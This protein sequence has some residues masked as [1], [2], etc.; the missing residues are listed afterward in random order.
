MVDEMSFV[1]AHSH[2]AHFALFKSE[3]DRVSMIFGRKINPG[4]V[5]RITF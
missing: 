2:F 5:M 4:M 1:F 3:L